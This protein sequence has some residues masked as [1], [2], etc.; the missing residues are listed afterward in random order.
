MELAK[1][2]NQGQITIPADIRKYLGIKGGDKVVLLKERGRVVMANSALL[3]LKEAQEAFKG[4]AEE[5]GL[6]NEQD[7]VAFIKEHRQN[8]KEIR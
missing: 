7:V 1:V 3:A 2:T 6:E 5:L 8:K 4:V